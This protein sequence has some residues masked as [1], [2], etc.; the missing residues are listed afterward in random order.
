MIEWLQMNKIVATVNSSKVSYWVHNP[1]VK[2][3]VIVVHG[4]RGNHKSLLPFIRN[5]KQRI[6][7]LDVPGYGESEPMKAKH[8]IENFAQYIGDFAEHIGVEKYSLIGHSYGASICIVLASMQ[9]TNLE[10]L[11]LINPA[12]PFESI[13]NNISDIYTQMAR[14]LPKPWRKTWLSNPIFDTLSAEIMIKNV[15]P[16]RKKQLMASGRQNLKETNPEVVVESL[17]SYRN[18]NIYLLA[19][20][21]KVPTLIIAGKLDPLAPLSKVNILLNTISNSVI[22][23]VEGHGHLVPLEVPGQTASLSIRFLAQ[24]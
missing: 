23:V 14:I 16:G 7:L 15:S 6:I 13:F 4:F 11:I 10:K 5:F 2:S 9:P 3:T 17:S 24:K 21:I 20:K 12:V 8:T 1:D 22:E 18:T 19:E